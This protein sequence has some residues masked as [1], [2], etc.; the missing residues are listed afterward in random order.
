VG[1]GVSQMIQ[2]T[3][4][5]GDHRTGLDRRKRRRGSQRRLARRKNFSSQNL[6]C[7]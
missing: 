3:L 1:A 6:A 4:G 2:P 5:T 7:L